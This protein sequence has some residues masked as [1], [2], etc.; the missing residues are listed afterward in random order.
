MINI[1]AIVRDDWHEPGWS[2]PGKPGDLAPRFAGFA[3]AARAL[4]AMPERWQKWALFDRRAA[5]P[6]RA[7]PRRR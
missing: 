3:P 6:S 1:V 5:A 7:G 2:A 4:I